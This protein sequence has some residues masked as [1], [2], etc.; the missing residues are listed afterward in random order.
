MIYVTSIDGTKVEPLIN[1]GTDFKM[2]QS[3]D[4]TFT[5]S[6]TCFQEQNNPGYELLKSEAII[7]VNDNDF[8]VKQYSNT[9]FSKTVTAISIFFDHAKT[10]QHATFSGSHT[11]QNHANF[12]LKDTGWTFTAESNIANITNYI[13]KFGD[14]NVVSLVTKI[15]KYHQCE[16]M[17][18]PG[19]MLYFAKQIGSDNDYQYSYKH[20]VSSV[21]LKE[22]TNNLATIIYGYGKDRLELE[23][24]YEQR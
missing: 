15:C 9:D 19:K 6:F 4:G 16:Y 14:D 24:L 23:T 13:S 3:V 21:M 17:I 18:L 11:L 5:V 10:R 1:I 12:A 2:E 8:R 22:D 7:T 20:N